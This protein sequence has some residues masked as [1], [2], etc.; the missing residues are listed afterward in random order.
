MQALSN[1]LERMPARNTHTRHT[2]TCTPATCAHDEDDGRDSHE[3]GYD[4]DDDADDERRRAAALLVIRRLRYRDFYRHCRWQ[5]TAVVNHHDQLHAR[6]RRTHTLDTS[7]RREVVCE[8][9]KGRTSLPLPN[10]Y[11]KP[12]GRNFTVTVWMSPPFSV[13]VRGMTSR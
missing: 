11:G 12:D 5:R 2:S 7:Q 4:A 9:R 10:Q 13:S 1:T 3:D 6:T 8:G